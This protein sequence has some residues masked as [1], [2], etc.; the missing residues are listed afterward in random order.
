MLLNMNLTI[1]LESLPFTYN[2]PYNFNYL[3]Y[4]LAEWFS[5]NLYGFAWFL[6]TTHWTAN[7]WRKLLRFNDC[8]FLGYEQVAQIMPIFSL[9]LKIPLMLPCVDYYLTKIR[10]GHLYWTS[11]FF[12]LLSI[13]KR[14]TSNW[15]W[16]NSFEFI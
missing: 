11:W 7:G 1:V 16:C 5:L 15:N 4:K 9:A 6:A 13:D 3:S 12:P 2:C 14:K 10:Q 8:I